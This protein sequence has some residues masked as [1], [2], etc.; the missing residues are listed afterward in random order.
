MYIKSMPET[1]QN[2]TETYEKSSKTLPEP[3]KRVPGSV[4]TV[5]LRNNRFPKGY[6]RGPARI[7]RAFSHQVE[8]G[9]I[10]GAPGA[11]RNR[12]KI[13]KNEGRGKQ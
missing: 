9:L 2:D 7:F 12:S 5:I 6:L 11:T 1:T 8:K 3:T 13:D 10:F 4:S